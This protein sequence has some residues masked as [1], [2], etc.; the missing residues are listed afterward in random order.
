MAQRQFRSDD[1]SKWTPKYGNGADGDKVVS[2]NSTY[3]GANA[4]LAS[5]ANSGQKNVSIDS[6]SSFANGDVVLIHQSRGTGAGAWELNRIASGG[7][8]TSLVMESDLINNYVESGASQAQVVELKQYK[9]LDVQSAKTWSAPVWDGSKGG[10]LAFLCKGLA[11][12]TG[13][14]SAKGADSANNNDNRPSGGGF[15]GGWSHDGTNST[16]QQGESPTGDG[17]QSNSAN[18]TGGGA[19]G[20][21]ANYNAGGGGGHATA[22]AS[23]TG[24][25]STNGS[26]GGTASDNAGMTNMVFGGGAGGAT[27]TAGSS[28]ASGANGGGL[29]VAIAKTLTITGAI[30]ADGGS[31]LSGARVTGGAGAG[32]GVLIKGVAVTIG[33]N[34][35][36]VAGGTCNSTPETGGAGGVGRIHVD[37]GKSLS[38]SASPTAADTRQ[39]KSLLDTMRGGSLLMQL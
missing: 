11:T 15:R 32:G 3:D 24:S 13:T 14:L 9:T 39:D 6:A 34:K 20:G 29:V 12:I 7:G 33:T 23:A 21:N 5:N 37:Y 27:G 8:S 26:G 4:G 19:G 31:N 38:G 30:N 10:I 1:T 28:T 2:S 22:G 36:S 35:I 17:S 18:G 16:G 25:N